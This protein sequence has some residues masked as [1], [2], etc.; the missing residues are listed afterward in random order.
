M[1]LIGQRTRWSWKLCCKREIHWWLKIK[2]VLHLLSSRIIRYEFTVTGVFQSSVSHRDMI[3]KILRIM[4]CSSRFV[5]HFTNSWK[6]RSTASLG[7]QTRDTIGFC[8]FS[9]KLD[10]FLCHFCYACRLSGFVHYL[11][12]PVQQE[13]HLLFDWERE[14]ALQSCFIN[15]D[16]KKD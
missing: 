6:L 7:V 8:L 3:L 1:I 16:F 2:S 13:W 14:R 11:I 10:Q 15:K 9:L 12:A 5:F 4:C